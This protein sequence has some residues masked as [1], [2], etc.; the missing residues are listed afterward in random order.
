M[1]N[2]T[3]QRQY[4]RLS[5]K[6]KTVMPTLRIQSKEFKI[7]E[8]SEQGMRVIVRDSSLFK[9]GDTVK[10]EVLLNSLE[11]NITV[12]GKVLRIVGN[13]VIFHLRE[14]LS[15]KDMIAEQRYLRK[16]FP[17]VLPKGTKVE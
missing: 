13:E 17:N 16:Y 1:T 12:E 5:Y 8:I 15:F 11:N 9:L 4:F 6:T 14:G 3:E 10:G 2:H 7:S